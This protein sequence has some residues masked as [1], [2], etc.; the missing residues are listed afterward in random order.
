MY[1]Y[2]YIYLHSEAFVHE[3]IIRFL[4][5]PPTCIDHTIAILLHVYYA[6]HDPPPT[7]PCVC[8]TLY[9]IGNGTS[10]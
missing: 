1:V 3:S 8:H 10:V 5:P 9:S 2:I 6:I 4:A 7:P